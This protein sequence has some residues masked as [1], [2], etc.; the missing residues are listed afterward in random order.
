MQWTACGFSP[1]KQSAIAMNWGSTTMFAQIKQHGDEYRKDKE[2]AGQVL[3]DSTLSDDRAR[4]KALDCVN[5]I[6]KNL[7]KVKR[8]TDSGRPTLRTAYLKLICVA[9]AHGA[10]NK[11][12]NWKGEYLG[13]WDDVA[14]RVD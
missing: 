12:L 6:F 8:K 7:E 4:F 11:A 9:L 14:T 1:E 3:H 10:G 2:L 5:K 13:Q